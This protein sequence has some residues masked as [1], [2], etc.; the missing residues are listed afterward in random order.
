MSRNTSFM[1]YVRDSSIFKKGKKGLNVIH[2]NPHFSRK[3]ITEVEAMPKHAS[4]NHDAVTGNDIEY[5]I[6]G[7]CPFYGRSVRTSYNFHSQNNG[8]SLFREREEID[9]SGTQKR[10]GPFCVSLVTTS[11]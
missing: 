7:Q 11:D 5:P 1:L 3:L 9:R 10:T 6:Y 4:H 2:V 8:V